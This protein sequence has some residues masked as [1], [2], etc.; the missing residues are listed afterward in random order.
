M[1]V[2]KKAS[3]TDTSLAH[4]DSTTVILP[5]PSLVLA[6]AS[7]RRLSL[8]SQI[9]IVPDIVCPADIDETAHRDEQ[10]RDIAKRL[11]QEKAQAVCRHFDGKFLLAADTVV[12]VG[13][14]ALGKA[15]S[16]DDAYGYLKL[17]TG[18]RHQV[19]TGVTLVTPTGTTVSRLVSSTVVFKPLGEHELRSYLQTDEWRGKAGG[20]GIQ[21][22]A[23][24][25]V[26]SI[27]GSYSN[28]VGLPLFEVS[29]MLIGNGFD[30]WAT[31]E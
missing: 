23:A 24:P 18:R 4:N 16:K 28:V 30:I 10:P 9:G 2:S 27:Q 17:L 13:R 22:R 11:S 5:F 12:A 14:R 25:F 7:P 19:H 21:G 29:N 6:S 26:R 3:A 15:E 20:Y 8:L 31:R 1:A